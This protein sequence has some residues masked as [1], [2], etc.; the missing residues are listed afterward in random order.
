MHQWQEVL[1][2]ELQ[3]LL[4]PSLTLCDRLGESLAEGSCILGREFCVWKRE[5]NVLVTF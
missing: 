3:V 2:R 5:V 4:C 1:R